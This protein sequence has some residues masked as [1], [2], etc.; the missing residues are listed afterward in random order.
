MATDNKGV[1]VYLP[2]ELEEAFEKYCTDNDITRKSKNGG[3]VL[4]LGVGIV[5]YLKRQM[6]GMDLNNG[7]NNGLSRN[8]LL[9]LVRESLINEG[10]NHVLSVDQMAE[11]A[12]DEIRQALTPITEDLVTM[13]SQ[14]GKLMAIAQD[15]L[16]PAVVQTYLARRSEKMAAEIEALKVNPP[17]NSSKESTSNTPQT[18]SHSATYNLS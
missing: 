10:S 1:T 9:N 15:D 7:V 3:E 18:K 6:L 2:P 4:S 17:V 5:H 12:R 14:I 13:Q 11:I 16:D 8:D